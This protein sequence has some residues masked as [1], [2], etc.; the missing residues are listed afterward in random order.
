MRARHH[1]SFEH[2]ALS[3]LIDAGRGIERERLSAPV[4]DDRDRVIVSVSKFADSVEV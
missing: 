4:G 3:A 2:T 1:R